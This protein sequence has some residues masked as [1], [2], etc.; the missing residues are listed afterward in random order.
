MAE[1]ISLGGRV[2]AGAATHGECVTELSAA[3]LSAATM[4][5]ETGSIDV[6]C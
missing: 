1:E 6:V 5:I 4:S 3:T 2:V